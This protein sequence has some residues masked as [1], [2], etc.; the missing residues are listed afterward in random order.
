[1]AEMTTAADL[2]IAGVKSRSLLLDNL[3]PEQ[4]R[5][6]EASG[7]FMVEVGGE[8]YEIR[9][10]ITER[11]SDHAKFCAFVPGLPVYDQMLARKLYLE[12]DPEAFF[13]A[14]NLFPHSGG[15]TNLYGYRSL[16]EQQF[17]IALTRSFSRRGMDARLIE[18]RVETVP[19]APQFAIT[20]SYARRWN[21]N[22][23]INMEHFYIDNLATVLESLAGYFADG[24]YRAVE[25]ETGAL[26]EPVEAR[27]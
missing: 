14:A 12:R 23:H 13:K 5:E 25:R 19:H 21:A 1:M 4:R 20:I 10:D 24:I 2:Q 26:V 6:F 16:A 3:T 17:W 11:A 9:H 15:I 22:H 8:R 27:R 18:M 7:T